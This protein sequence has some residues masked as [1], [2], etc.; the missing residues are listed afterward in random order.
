MSVR[1]RLLLMGLKTRM[2]SVASV[3]CP[4][5]VAR[6]KDCIDDFKQIM[7]LVEELANPALKT[8]HWEQIFK[9]IDADIPPNDNG[10]GYAPFSVRML[11]QVRRGVRGAAGILVCTPFPM[12]IIHKPSL[13]SAGP[14]PC[15]P[16]RKRMLHP[17]RGHLRSHLS[18]RVSCFAYVPLSG[19]VSND[20]FQIP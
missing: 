12:A 7:P 13:R 1:L 14:S 20:R 15:P 19:L 5:V 6:L 4:Q 11:L 10:V 2:P 16:M 8:R 3:R 18:L 17:R 9:V